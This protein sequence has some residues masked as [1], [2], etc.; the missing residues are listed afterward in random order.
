MF[1]KIIATAFI[2][3][4][5]SASFAAGCQVKDVRVCEIEAQLKDFTNGRSFIFQEM[6]TTSMSVAAEYEWSLGSAD[7]IHLG[8]TRQFSD[9]ALFFLIAH[10]IGHAVHGDGRKTVEHFA[11]VE[12]RNLPDLELLKKYRE[13]TLAGMDSAEEMNHAHEYAADAFA[14]LAMLHAGKNPIAAMSNVLKVRYPDSTHPSRHQRIV[15]AQ[16]LVSSYQVSAS[17]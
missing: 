12:D 4:A 1:K 16:E 13:K 15:K 2:A 3:L 14:V 6:S 10:E 9:N 5:A 11:A 8:D 7:V 17:N